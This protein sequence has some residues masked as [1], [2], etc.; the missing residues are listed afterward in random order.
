[1]YLYTLFEAIVGIIAGLVGIGLTVGMYC[2][3]AGNLLRSLN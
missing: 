3:F 1:M 2:L